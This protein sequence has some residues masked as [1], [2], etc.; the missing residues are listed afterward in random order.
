MTTT[1]N[2]GKTPAIA[3]PTTTMIMTTSTSTKELKEIQHFRSLT[4]DNK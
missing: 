1:T 4:H 2:D 3:R